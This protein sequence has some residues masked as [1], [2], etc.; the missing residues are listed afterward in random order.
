[1]FLLW[2]PSFSFLSSF[3]PAAAAS[4]LASRIIWLIRGAVRIDSDYLLSVILHSRVIDRATRNFQLFS[5]RILG[6]IWIDPAR[7]DYTVIVDGNLKLRRDG[8]IFVKIDLKFW[9]FLRK[10][11]YIYIYNRIYLIIF[12]NLRIC[13]KKSKFKKSRCFFFF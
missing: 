10:K 11:K 9:Y 12:K 2:P 8:W 3:P 6:E 7:V 13:N 1:M 4:S 5:S